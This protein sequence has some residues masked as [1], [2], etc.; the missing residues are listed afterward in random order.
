MK[1]YAFLAAF[2]LPALSATAYAQTTEE[3][4]ARLSAVERKLDAILER[5]D[6]S[7]EAPPAIDAAALREARS[8]IAAGAAQRAPAS[9]KA[10]PAPTSEASSGLDGARVA[11]GG[12]VKLDLAATRFTAG[13][14]PTTSIGRDFYIPSLV[15]AGGDG[16]GAVLDFNPR[17]TRVFFDVETH[18]SGHAIGGRIELDFQVTTEGNERVSNSYVPRLRQA[19]FTYDNWLFGQAWTTFQNVSALPDNL[20]FI[21]PT[22]GVVFERQAQIRYSRG[23]WRFAL[24][25]PETEITIADG[26]RRLPGDDILPDVVLRYGREGEW[27][28]VTAAGIVRA[29]HIEEDL[30][31]GARKDTA[32]GYGVSLSGLVKSGGQDDF[33]MMLTAGRGIGRYVGLNI[34]NDASLDA[35]GRIDTIGVLSGFLSY[36]HLW[37]RRLR[38]NLTG[39]FF[40]ADHPSMLSDSAVTDRVGSIHANLIFS[41]VRALDLG[42]ELILAN[43]RTENGASGTMQRL[44]F[45][46][47]YGF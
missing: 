37:T 11:L 9:D 21:G 47:K 32:L 33:R 36:R 22:E 45:S 24:E 44:Q 12:Y 23:P 27:G 15:P 4:D 28:G 1:S 18:R 10:P 8:L 38:S 17:E 34:V 2:S 13:E 25:Q 19:Y 43:R 20:D 31:P 5:L 30:A 3:L 41:P 26:T 29:L 16:D 6:E 39:G 35:N 46:A 40:F 14:L 7:G 42:G